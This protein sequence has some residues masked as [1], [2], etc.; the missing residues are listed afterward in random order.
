MSDSI[1]N[2]LRHVAS[3]KGFQRRRGLYVRSCD[4]LEQRLLVDR[5]PNSEQRSIEVFILI[6]GVDDNVATMG[7][8]DRDCEYS[9]SVFSGRTQ[10]ALDLLDMAKPIAD[11]ERQARLVELM[12][13]DLAPILELTA[14]KD[15][16]RRLAMNPEIMLG[17]GLRPLVSFF[18][19]LELP[20][21]D[22][23][24]LRPKRFLSGRH[25]TEALAR[26]VD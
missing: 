16:L 2:A 10:E 6:R 14:T 17:L 15:R 26:I 4:G 8:F 5:S 9:F 12:N 18:E 20:W 3:A 19:K 7:K 1:K 25:R 21:V 11:D 13:S 24:K 23:A 22:F